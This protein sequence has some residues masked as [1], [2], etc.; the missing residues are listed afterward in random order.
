MIK[1]RLTGDRFTIRRL[2]NYGFRAISRTLLLPA[3]KLSESQLKNN[4]RKTVLKFQNSLPTEL[5]VNTGDIVVQVGT[6]WPETLHR[7]RKAVGDSGKLIIVEAMTDNYDRLC[8]ASE[9]Q[10]Y[11]NVH[12]VH[13]AAWSHDKDGIL[14]VSEHVG[15]HK[16]PQDDVTMDND[17]R[18]AN[19]SMN[20]VPTKFYS[21]DSVLENLNIKLINYLSVT[22]NGAELEVL[23]GAA[24]TLNNSNNCRIYSKAHARLADGTP[25]HQPIMNYLQTIGY[26][27]MKTKGEASSTNDPTWMIRDGD[28]YAWKDHRYT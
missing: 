21:I 6:P 13:G 11:K 4:I 15:D 27:V 19:T 26:T 10:S 3:T 28:V 5:A 23:K 12:I 20:E 25:L 24:N 17:L 2:K 16:I 1:Y 14:L 8:E 9:K 7:F 18:E 22:V